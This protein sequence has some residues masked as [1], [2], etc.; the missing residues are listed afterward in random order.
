M[1]NSMSRILVG[2]VVKNALREMRESPER[3]IRNLIDMALQFSGGRF[4][5]DFFTIAQTMLQ[6]ENSAYY[7][8]VRDIISHTDAERLYTFGMDLGYNA[9]TAGAR[10]IRENEKK[11]GCNI[12]WT[13]PLRICTDDFIGK[14]PRY[15]AVISSGEELGIYSWM[16]FCGKQPKAVLPLV[17]EHP[18]SAFFLFCEPEDMN[19]DFLDEAVGSYHLMPVVRYDKDAADVCDALRQREMLYSI[20]YP[21]GQKDTEAIL[22]GG[23]FCSAQELS[24]VFTALL[25]EPACPEVI[26]RLVYQTVQRARN[27]QRY[28]TMLWELQG[29]NCLVDA[30]ISDDACSV[31][32]D[33]DGNI[34]DRGGQIVCAHHNLLESNLVDIFMDACPKTKKACKAV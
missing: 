3:S 24:P 2:A 13:V 14:E 10:R 17:E 31:Y 9:C 16:L 4:Q 19:A 11:L 1:E 28:H 34:C 12:P 32:F 29:D 20:W 33:E 5:Q 26:Q 22:N 6:N 30:I 8:L 27:D 7:Q 25:P 15:Q 23:L 18:D 21:Y